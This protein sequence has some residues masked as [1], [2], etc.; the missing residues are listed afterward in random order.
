MCLPGHYINTKYKINTTQDSNSDICI[1]ITNT[2]LIIMKSFKIDFLARFESSNL[3]TRILLTF[4]SPILWSWEMWSA[5]ESI[6]VHNVS[7]YGRSGIQSV[8][9]TAQCTLCTVY[10]TLYTIHC[11]LYTVHCTLYTVHYTLF[12]WHCT[13]HT[14]YCTLNDTHW[15]CLI[16]HYKIFTVQCTLHT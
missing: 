11:T 16:A 4:S 5:R 15:K 6:S 14:K 1:C 12:T 7:F 2:I 9:C 13:V 10:C 8:P 3:T